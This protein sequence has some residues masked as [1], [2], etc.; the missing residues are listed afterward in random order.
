MRT[1]RSRQCENC[2]SL[3]PRRRRRTSTSREAIRGY[4]ELYFSRL[5]VLGE[6]PSEEI[7]L[8]RLFRAYGHPLDTNFISVVPLGGRHVNHFWRLLEGLKIP[9]ITLLDLD[10]EKQGGGWGRI[11]YVRDQLLKSRE[12]DDPRLQLKSEP[13]TW[14]GDDTISNIRDRAD[15]DVRTMATWLGMLGER[16]GVYFSAPLDIDFSM[17][18]AFPDAYQEL[19]PDSGGPNLPAP[20]DPGYDE[21]VRQR[22]EMVLSPGR[23]GIRRGPR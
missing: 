5:V 23:S 8:R 18:E 14:L 16:F 2:H 15:S 1:P 17:L 12:P 19:A 13:E 4:P 21:A 22:V 9:Y 20:E 10:R 11:A 7:V 6:G 3:I